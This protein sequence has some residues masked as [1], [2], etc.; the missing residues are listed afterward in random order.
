MLL[1]FRCLFLVQWDYFDGHEP[2]NEYEECYHCHQANE[3]HK[4]CEPVP[5]VPE[6]ADLKHFE[7]DEDGDEDFNV[8]LHHESN[9]GGKYWHRVELAPNPLLLA[10][11]VS[12]GIDESLLSEPRL[13][14]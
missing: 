1:E 6:C 2:A 7:G 12:D 11:C 8:C 4:D 9:P 5:V 3:M 10:H 14:G 13:H